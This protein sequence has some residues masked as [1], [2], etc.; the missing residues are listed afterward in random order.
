M[1]VKLTHGP[2]LRKRQPRGAVRRH[3][4]HDTDL[5]AYVPV[6]LGERRNLN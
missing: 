5:R 4:L 1:G 6:D 3:S 2:R